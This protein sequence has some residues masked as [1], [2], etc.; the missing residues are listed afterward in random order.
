MR[1]FTCP[2]CGKPWPENY[3]PECGQTIDRK[4]QQ[5]GAPPDAE[6]EASPPQV[7]V[8]P[9]TDR[10]FYRRTFILAFLAALAPQLVVYCFFLSFGTDNATS[11]I[12]PFGDVCF[13]FYL[14]VAYLMC[15]LPKGIIG[16]GLAAFGFAF[17]VAPAVGS[18]AYS[19]IFAFAVVFFRRVTKHGVP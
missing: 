12:T 16:T 13:S 10:T 14:P 3:C 5:D 19:V 2:N 4:P 6:E 15:L 7:E 17:W 9:R 8:T 18:V 11:G 1:E